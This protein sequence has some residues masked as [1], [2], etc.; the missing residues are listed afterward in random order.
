MYYWQFR[1]PSRL[2]QIES[3]FFETRQ[4]DNATIRQFI[5]FLTHFLACVPGAFAGNLNNKASDSG[6]FGPA[7][8]QRFVIRV[9]SVPTN[10][11]YVKGTKPA[12]PRGEK[13]QV[14]IQIEQLRLPDGQPMQQLSVPKEFKKEKTVLGVQ[15]LLFYVTVSFQ[16]LRN[17]TATLHLKHQTIAFNLCDL[18]MTTSSFFDN[19]LSDVVA[20]CTVAKVSNKMYTDMTAVH[21]KEKKRQSDT[22]SSSA[23]DKASSKPTSKGG[24]RAPLSEQELKAKADREAFKAGTKIP[25][26]VVDITTGDDDGAPYQVRLLVFIHVPH[27]TFRCE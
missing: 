2:I 15:E 11:A 1:S 10:I 14:P 25:W 23:P 7:W 6:C 8:C 16:A 24:K 3:I 12:R 22:T 27:V 13:K 5:F 17:F 21:R 18:C 19:V 9:P 26:A 20:R 4:V